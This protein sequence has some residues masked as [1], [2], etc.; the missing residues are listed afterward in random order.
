MLL[1][2]HASCYDDVVKCECVRVCVTSRDS[3]ASSATDAEDIDYVAALLEFSSNNLKTLVAIFSSSTVSVYMGV[4]TI[5]FFLVYT[6]SFVVDITYIL[7][8]GLSSS[9]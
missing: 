6:Q 7:L 1:C 5:I 8:Y 4:C 3:T 9:S 2:V